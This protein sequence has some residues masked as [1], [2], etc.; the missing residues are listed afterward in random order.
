MV[1]T[2]EN[3][4]L[5]RTGAG[6][7]MGALMRQYW[8]PFAL[9]KDVEADGVPMRVRLLGDDLLAFRD[10][11]GRVGLVD[12]NCPHRRAPLYFGRNEECGLRCVYHGWKF[13]VDGKCVDMPNERPVSN[14]MSKVQLASYPCEERGGLLWAYLNVG[15]APP[16]LPDFEWACVPE[17][18]VHLSIR[19]ERCNWLQC[20]EGEIDSSHGPFLHSRIDGVASSQKS[21]AYELEDKHPKLESLEMDHGL[22]IAARRDLD[23]ENY[24][25]RINLFALP[26]YTMAPPGGSDPTISGHAWVPMDDTHTVCVMFT[27]HP[28]T[29]LSDKYRSLFRDGTFS[30]RETGHLSNRAVAEHATGRPF[31]K[32]WTRFGPENDYEVDWEVQRISHYSGL[33]GVWVQDAAC[34]EGMGPITDRTKERLG[35]SDVGIIQTRRLL[36]RLARELAADGSVPVSASDPSVMKVRS[37]GAVLK[38]EEQWADATKALIRPGLT[39]DPVG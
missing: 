11:N 35:A 29:P 21:L 34:Q 10:T 24:Y 19:I 16:P 15:S 25:W 23:D 36:I 14:F 30:G 1:T 22:A 20:L 17:E 33:P 37:V 28:T 27:Y 13:D 4:L 32:Y 38:R 31:P 2:E 9:G 26:F 6:T 3:E 7:P 5:T 39:T 18:N 12:P 8:L